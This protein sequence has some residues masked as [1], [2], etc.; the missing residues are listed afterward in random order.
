MAA[1]SRFQMDLTPEELDSIERW[2]AFAGFRTK[3]DFFLN[4]FTLF[5]WAAKQILLGRSI[6]AINEATGEVRH[7]EMPG[8]AAIAAKTR[9]TVLSM[10]EFDRRS[11]EPGKPF[12][13]FL[14]TL[15]RMRLAVEKK[16]EVTSDDEPN[17]ELA[18]IL[19]GN[20][21]LFNE[22]LD[23]VL[24]IRSVLATDPQSFVEGYLRDGRGRGILLEV[25]PHTK[26]SLSWFS[27]RSTRSS[28]WSR[29]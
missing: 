23:G 16:W 1:L 17:N 10:E 20:P 6:C 25:L 8:L 18:R 22:V 19:L 15:K 27:S 28:H 11:A 24:K 4:A 13:E 9:P 7:L 26:S 2:S 12:A 14:P 3:R 5:Q 21:H 29:S